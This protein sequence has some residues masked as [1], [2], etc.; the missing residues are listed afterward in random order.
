ML[1]ATF[2]MKNSYSPASSGN[3]KRRADAAIEAIRQNTLDIIGTQEL[4]PKT[5]DYLES[6]LNEYIFVGDSRGSF[7]ISDEYNCILLK[8]AEFE[9]LNTETYSLSNNIYKRGGKF[10]FDIFPRIGTIAHVVHENQKYLIIN[11]HLDNLFG[12]NR[13]LQLEVLSEIIKLEKTDDEEIIIM[14][15]FN[16]YLKGDLKKFQKSN[17]LVN[18]VPLNLGSSFRKLK[19]KAPIDYIFVSEDLEVEKTKYD[20]N[21]Y[22]GIYPSDHYPVITKLK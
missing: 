10:L 22:N 7:G 12:Y 6:K 17:K 13:K 16:M 20:E 1:V 19:R 21:E 14:G 2:N 5:K 3:P 4:T 8:R 11:T 18:A 15:D 9:L